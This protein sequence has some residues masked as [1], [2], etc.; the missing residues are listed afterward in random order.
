MSHYFPSG[1]S[2]ES[3]VFSHI[4]A[5]PI[6]WSTQKDGGEAQCAAVIVRVSMDV[7]ILSGTFGPL[8]IHRNCHEFE[9]TTAAL[10]HEAANCK[11]FTAAFKSLQ[12]VKC[13]ILKTFE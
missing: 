9:L 13:L 6:I 1:S 4:L 3:S 12:W 11:P 2:S 5:K 10:L 8:Q 7:L